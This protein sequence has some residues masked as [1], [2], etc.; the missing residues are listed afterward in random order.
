[1]TRAPASIVNMRLSA[2]LALTSLTGPAGV[3]ARPPREPCRRR[4]RRAP[5]GGPRPRAHAN[6]AR[7]QSRPMGGADR[8]SAECR[9]TRGGRAGRS[10]TVAG[11]TGPA[12]FA[13]DLLLAAGVD[14]V[15]HGIGARLRCSFCL[16]ERLVADRS[17]PPPRLPEWTLGEAHQVSCRAQWDKALGNCDACAQRSWV[18][19]GVTSSR[20][21]RQARPGSAAR[22]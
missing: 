6:G 1:M 18:L 20:R 2:R 8:E 5:S 4:G 3:G 12:A 19:E 10:G 11:A 15:A 21:R 9:C 17:A 16:R 7:T 14:L 22:A 13:A